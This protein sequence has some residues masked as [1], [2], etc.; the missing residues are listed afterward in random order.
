MQAQLG[1]V[2]HWYKHKM[3]GLAQKGLRDGGEV[4]RWVLF[5]GLVGLVEEVIWPQTCLFKGRPNDSLN[6]DM[7]LPF[8]FYAFK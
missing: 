7:H 1:Q 4:Y 5:R 3:Y 6:F 8:D 2:V